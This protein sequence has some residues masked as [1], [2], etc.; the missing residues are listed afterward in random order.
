MAVAQFC[1]DRLVSLLFDTV[2]SPVLEVFSSVLVAIAD[3]D[4]SS[5]PWKEAN[6]NILVHQRKVQFVV[7][8]IKNT[9]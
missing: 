6:S 3:A 5:Q 7:E 9:T 8:K 1:K 4:N 2:V